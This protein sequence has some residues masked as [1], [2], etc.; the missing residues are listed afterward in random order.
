MFSI[1]VFRLSL[2]Y[3]FKNA[4]ER[5]EDEEKTLQNG[6]IGECAGEFGTLVILHGEYLTRDIVQNIDNYLFDKDLRNYKK[7][8]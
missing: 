3:W 5:T 8:I 4:R 1:R 7:Y 6:Q 2:L